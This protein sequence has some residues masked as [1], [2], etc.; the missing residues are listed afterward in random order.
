[1][2]F[3]NL[4]RATTRL[5]GAVEVAPGERFAVEIDELAAGGASWSLDLPAGVVLLER[6]SEPRPGFG[7]GA[8]LLYRF[9]C[10]TTGDHSL[11]F[12]FGRPWEAASKDFS[13][14]VRCSAAAAR[15]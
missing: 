6:E 1:M 12:A 4:P 14:T 13:V 7:G 8:R 15:R 11:K 2:A 5:G 9:R 3:L 10:D